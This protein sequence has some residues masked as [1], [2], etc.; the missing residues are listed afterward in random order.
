MKKLYYAISMM[1][2]TNYKSDIVKTFIKEKINVIKNGSG[3]SIDTLAPAMF[4]TR[5]QKPDKNNYAAQEQICFLALF[6]HAIAACI[7][8]DDNNIYK[9]DINGLENI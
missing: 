7:F 2:E 9:N 1:Q 4:K 5:I 8:A 3:L 6:S